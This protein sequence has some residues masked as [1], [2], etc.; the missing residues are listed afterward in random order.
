M[1]ALA[2]HAVGRFTLV[3]LPED[4]GSLR[5]DLLALVARWASPLSREERAAAS[6]VGG[7]R[8]DED[9]R[10]GGGGAPPR[11]G[12]PPPPRRGPPRRTRRG[13]GPAPGPRRHRDR[14]AL[15]RAR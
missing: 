4:A 9:L 6:L 3:D 15:G 1:A 11:R 8:H 13:A 5:G 7:A 10:A 2:R 14:R 12:R